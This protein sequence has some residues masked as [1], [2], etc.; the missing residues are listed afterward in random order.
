MD[1]CLCE[2]VCE[3]MWEGGGGHKQE[4]K[5]IEKLHVI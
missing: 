4:K 2:C 5:K 1:E 3:H